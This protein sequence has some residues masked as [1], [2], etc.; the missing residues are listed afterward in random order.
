MTSPVAFVQE[1][2]VEL[3]K[4]VWPHRS[5]VTRLTFVVIII[6]LLVGLYVGGLDA[7]FTKGLTLL[8]GR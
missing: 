5:E 8:I 3:T 6:S 7:L 4:V 2:R 1:V